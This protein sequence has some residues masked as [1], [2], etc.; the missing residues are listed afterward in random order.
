MKTKGIA[1]LCDGNELEEFEIRNEVGCAGCKQD[2]HVEE[3]L[4]RRRDESVERSAQSEI[5]T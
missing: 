4:R 3:V 5:G 2:C 1:W